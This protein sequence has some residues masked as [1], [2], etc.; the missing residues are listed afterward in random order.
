MMRKKKSAEA[1]PPPNN[2]LFV[3]NSP[4]TFYYLFF[5]HSQKAC[6]GTTQPK[7]LQMKLWLDISHLPS[8]LAVN[9]LP[10]A[11]SHYKFFFDDK[12]VFMTMLYN[13]WV[14]KTT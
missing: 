4:P 14:K 3:S 8:F 9:F 5:P 7:R 1:K 6:N 10:L 12:I 2:L 11:T 13:L